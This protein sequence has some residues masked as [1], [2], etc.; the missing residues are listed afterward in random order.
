MW[1]VEM[2]TEYLGTDHF[3]VTATRKFRLKSRATA[4]FNAH[5]ATLKGGT[6]YWHHMPVPGVRMREVKR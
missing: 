6:G 1:V 4:F 3:V 2:G 5:A